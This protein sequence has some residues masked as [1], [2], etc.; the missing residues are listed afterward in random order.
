NVLQTFSKNITENSSQL[1]Q[2]I[3]ESSNMTVDQVQNI[4]TAT[5]QTI[6]QSPE[7]R[8]TIATNTNAS[9]SMVQQITNAIPQVITVTP[10]GTISTVKEVAQSSQT[11]ETTSQKIIQALMSTAVENSSFINSL[12][13]EHHLKSQQIKNILTTYARNV[14]QPTET[15]IQ[16]INESSGV[17]KDQVRSIILSLTGSILASG[18]VI[19]QVAEAEGVSEA[20]VSNV[21]EKQLE[22]A[23][24]PEKYIE[25]AISIPETISLEDYE[26]VKEMWIKHYEE[27]EVPVTETIK[28]RTD[29]IEQE[30]VYITNTLNKILSPDEKLQQ[31][32]L[33]ELGYLLPIFLINNLKGE[34]LIVY[35]K[36]K[37]EAAKLV[38]KILE[39]E[40]KL[41]EKMKETE[42]EEMFVDVDQKEKAEEPKHMAMDI[43]EESQV[44]KSIEDR[45]K[46]IQEKLSSIDSPDN[47]K[48]NNLSLSGIKNRLKDA[49]IPEKKS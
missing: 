18:D 3:A 23:S 28:T 25:K 4:M 45:V 41:K 14:N 30:V 8:S 13:E 46:A 21:M 33:D 20:D 48:E 10:S 22:L 43:D 19:S 7:I 6:Q 27:G 38:M 12:A 40:Q 24:E 29:W 31:E 47:P 44:P 15:L 26:E 9:E 42:D 49:S 32:G 5:S 2:T 35:L 11:N 1:V 16:T 17:P 37:L 39:R 36:A 34:E